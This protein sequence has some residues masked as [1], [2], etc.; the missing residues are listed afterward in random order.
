MVWLPNTS[1]IGGAQEKKKGLA[2]PYRKQ[3]VRP[4]KHEGVSCRER[5]ACTRVLNRS[6]W[7]QLP[8][9]GEFIGE[10]YQ[11]QSLTSVSFAAKY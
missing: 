8:S 7:L 2:R 9:I 6:A 11:H 5:W 4:E 10:K 1:C 3:L